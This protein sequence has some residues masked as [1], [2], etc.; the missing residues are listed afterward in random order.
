MSYKVILES[1]EYKENKNNTL[2]TTYETIVDVDNEQEAFLCT[3]DKINEETQCS[4]DCA[5]IVSI[6]NLQEVNDE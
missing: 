4:V 2:P 3:I 1:I 5:V 6:I